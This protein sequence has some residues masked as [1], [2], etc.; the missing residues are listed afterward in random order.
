MSKSFLKL[1]PW[2]IM[3]LNGCIQSIPD[4]PNAAKINPPPIWHEKFQP[5]HQQPEQQWWKQ[6]H[7]PVLN[8]LIE[9][10]LKHNTDIAL[11]QTRIQQALAQE[12]AIRSSLLPSL[13]ASGGTTRQKSLN[14]FGVATLSRVEQPTFQAAYELDI[15]GKNRQN[16]KSARLNRLA[17]EMAAESTRISV[18]STTVKAYITL[19][20]LDEKLKLLQ[21]TLE[22][23]QKELQLANAKARVGYTSQ[24]ELNQA[25]AEY[26]ATLQQIP[27]IQSSIG[28]QEHLISMLTG[29]SSQT[30][31][32]GLSLSELH[33]PA[34]PDILPSELM[35]NRPDIVQSSLL[36]AASDASLAA[37]QA[38]FFPTVRISAAFGRI[39]STAPIKEPINVWSIG[40]SVLAPIFEGGQIKANFDLNVAKRNEAVW[41]YRK[42]VL[43]A[44]K[45][46]EDQLSAGYRLQEQQKALQME[47]DAVASALHHARN[48]Y[49]A[50]YSSYI[51]VLDSQRT[52]FSVQ[53]QLIQSQADYLTSQVSLYQALGGGWVVPNNKLN[54]KMN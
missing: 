19:R 49:Q 46:V 22:A 34:I 15:F 27:I 52:L 47:R 3:G 16:W 5:S 50:G 45:E 18:I 30:I 6:L 11:A 42:V 9:E 8:Q 43:T 17:T 7:D 36:L 54:S 37:A 20:A 25:Q 2:I 14:A 10:A 26:A 33:A 24:L 29:S 31:Q 53:S 23:R 38:Q 28:Q 44:M 51:E 12:H 4:K 32:R 39:F 35:K 41:N 40:G 13:N 48:R 1:L 21:Q